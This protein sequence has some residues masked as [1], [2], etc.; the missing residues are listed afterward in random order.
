MNYGHYNYEENCRRC[1][2]NKCDEYN[3]WLIP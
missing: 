3:N 2:Y 1:E